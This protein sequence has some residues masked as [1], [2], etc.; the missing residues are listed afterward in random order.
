MFICTKCRKE[1]DDPVKFCTECGSKNMICDQHDIKPANNPDA[2]EYLI[3]KDRICK[4]MESKIK[5][6]RLLSSKA[7]TEYMLVSKGYYK[8]L[9]KSYQ[10]FQQ[11]NFTE[12][13]EY[14]LQA[15]NILSSQISRSKKVFIGV[16]IVVILAAAVLLIAASA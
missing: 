16:I 12:A 1:F 5:F 9:E 4:E 7:C 15:Q 6:N 8:C 14:L 2:E 13:R 3:L 10:A 11:N